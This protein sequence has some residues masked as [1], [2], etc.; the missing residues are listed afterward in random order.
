[1]LRL[2]VFVGVVAFS[3]ASVR[4]AATSD[5]QAQVIVV[6]YFDFDA[7]MNSSYLEIV[8]STVED[9]EETYNVLYNPKQIDVKA[10]NIDGSFAAVYTVRGVDCNKVSTASLPL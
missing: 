4:Q 3:W 9:L 6:T 7:D 2:V 5:E 1:M 8:R 10:A